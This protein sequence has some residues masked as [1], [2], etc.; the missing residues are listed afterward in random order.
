MGA[1]V[2]PGQWVY[3]VHR[4]VALDDAHYGPADDVL[5][6]KAVAL[7]VHVPRHCQPGA[8]SVDG[9]RCEAHTAVC[10][11]VF[12]Q[13]KD[14]IVF[15]SLDQ[16][17]LVLRDVA[18][19]EVL[20]KR[21][22]AANLHILGLDGEWANLQPG[23]LLPGVPAELRCH[24]LVCEYYDVDVEGAGRFWVAL[25]HLHN[26]P[27]HA[28]LDAHANGELK[29]KIHEVRHAVPHLGEVQLP[30]DYLHWAMDQRVADRHRELREEQRLGGDGVPQLGNPDLD[31]PPAWYH[32]QVH[33]GAEEQ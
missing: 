32:G 22:L 15:S 25:L 21:I 18:G 19:H 29:D 3:V 27:S 17:D 12:C 10:L 11:A 30:S 6:N 20:A 8:Q 2:F 26:L 14:D 28:A 7:L 16:H 31:H 9:W 1:V 13:Q 33:H 23:Y 4:C 5:R 24:L